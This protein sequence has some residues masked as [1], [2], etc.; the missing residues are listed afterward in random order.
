MLKC[1]GWDSSDGIFTC[2]K[3]VIA[4]Q[5]AECLFKTAYIRKMPND[6]YRVISE[7]GKNLGESNSRKDAEQRLKEVEIFKHLNR[8]KRRRRKQAMMCMLFFHK[9]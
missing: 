4:G 9:R 8:R 7:K 5:C 3:I 6:K 1:T 2:D